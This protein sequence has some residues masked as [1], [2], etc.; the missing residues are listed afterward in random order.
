LSSKS[1][2]TFFAG[3]AAVADSADLF[4]LVVKGFGNVADFSFGL[5]VAKGR[6]ARRTAK[7][8]Q[9]T[10]KMLASIAFSLKEQMF[11]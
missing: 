8:G 3:L 4:L 6:L 9:R 2:L 1:N 11:P 5:A 7:L 10:N